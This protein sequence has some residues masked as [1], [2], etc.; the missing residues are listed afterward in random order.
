MSGFIKK[1]ILFFVLIMV[2][3]ISFSNAAEAQVVKK[4]SIDEL[5]TYIKSAQKPMVVN[6]W[7]TFCRPC[8]DE[9]PYFLSSQQLHPEVE[10]VMVSLDLPGYYPTKIQQFLVSK[11]FGGGTQF[12]LN[13]TNADDFCPRIDPSWDGAIP[14]TL[15]INPAKQYRKF[16]N[17]PMTEAQINLAYKELLQ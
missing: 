1:N 17:R 12:W 5:D 10:F 13:E 9:L 8:I 15:W 14:V 2:H 11:N 7:A 6:F 3:L 4:V 16:V